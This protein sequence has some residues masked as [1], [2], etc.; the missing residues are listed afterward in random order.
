M[1][2]KKDSKRQTRLK[3]LSLHPLKLDDALKGLMQA[4]PPK[5]DKPKKRKQK[6]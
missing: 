4:P 5:D 2:T 6:K 3:P 1:R